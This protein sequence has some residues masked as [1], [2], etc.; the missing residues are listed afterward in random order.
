MLIV[1]TIIGWVLFAFT[2]LLY[3]VGN[4]Q[5]AAETNA[6]AI[7]SLAL[8]LSDNFRKPT[9][10]GML[11]AAREGRAAGVAAEDLAWRLRRAVTNI[12][13]S[14]FRPGADVNSIRVVVAELQLLS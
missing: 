8:I 10:D 7:F 5:N 3:W 11:R 13:S 6:L 1:I 12:A 14:H 9:A 4:R 2:V